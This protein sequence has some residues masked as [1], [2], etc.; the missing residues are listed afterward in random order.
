M[1]L[2]IIKDNGMTEH[3][4]DIAK[5]AGIAPEDI[6][7]ARDRAEALA[8]IAKVL[9]DIAVVDPHL[10]KNERLEDGLGVIQALRKA[11]RTCIILCLTTRG[12]TDLG[13]RA[14]E[15]GADDYIDLDRSYVNG[16]ED[17]RARL[18]I[19]RG[20]VMAREAQE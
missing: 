7:I 3:V 5:E 17:L 11:S 9:P 13:V 8:L 2:V 1:K 15:S 16:W 6:L 4:A 18:K 12:S 20:V 14:Y 10:T 19:A